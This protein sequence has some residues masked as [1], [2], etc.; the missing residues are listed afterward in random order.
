MRASIDRVAATRRLRP[1]SSRTAGRS[2]LREQTLAKSN[3]G[4]LLLVGG[5]DNNTA[6]PP[7]RL[8]RP[9]LRVLR[10]EPPIVTNRISYQKNSFSTQKESF[11][12]VGAG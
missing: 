1:S 8:H 9:L 11:F 12:W 5:G 10:V 6:L 7:Y 4:S 2:G 3:W